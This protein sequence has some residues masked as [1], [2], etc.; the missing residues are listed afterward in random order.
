MPAYSKLMDHPQIYKYPKNKPPVWHFLRNGN[1]F[2]YCLPDGY[3]EGG[4]KV[5]MEAMASGLPVITDNHS[6]MKDRVTEKTG[7]LCDKW[8]DYVEVVKYLINNPNEI[9]EKG[10]AAK[11]HAKKQFVA[12]RWIDEILGD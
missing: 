6:G 10:L 2:F 11:E 5:V 9:M 12:S 1:C 7:W 8:E 4:P 3:T